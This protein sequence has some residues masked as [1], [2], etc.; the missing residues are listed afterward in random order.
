MGKALSGGYKPAMLAKATE[1]GANQDTTA[2]Y[3]ATSRK[4]KRYTVRNRHTHHQFR[5]PSRSG[6]AVYPAAAKLVPRIFA[7]YIQTTVRALH[8]AFEAGYK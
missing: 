3:T 5:S 4:G 6:Y 7:A 2:S 1:F 8:E